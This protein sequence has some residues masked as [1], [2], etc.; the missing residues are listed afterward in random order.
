MCLCLKDLEHRG[1]IKVHYYNKA[2]H[3]HYKLTAGHSGACRK[4]CG[5]GEIAAPFEATRSGWL[6]ELTG[7]FWDNENAL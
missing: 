3:L 7:L 2:A 5:L 6:M 1:V 4:H